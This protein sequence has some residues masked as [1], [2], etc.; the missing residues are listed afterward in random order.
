MPTPDQ[1]KRTQLT[2]FA[3]NAFLSLIM[4][5]ILALPYRARVR[6]MGWVV[7]WVIAPLAGYPKRVIANLDLAWPSLPD[8]EKKRLARAV[9]NNFGRTLIEIYSGAEYK[10]HLAQ[11]PLEGP[12]VDALQ[13]AH[14]AGRPIILVSGH[15]GNHDAIRA[16]V[17]DRFS[18]VG[19]LYRPLGNSYINAHW[20]NAVQGIASPA[21]ARGRRGL[22]EMVKYLRQGN[23]IAL[24]VDQY[25]QEGADLTFFGKQARTTLSAAELA[26][27]YDALFL[28]VFGLRKAD[29]I[30]FHPILQEPIAHS[31]AVQ[32]AQEMNDRLE[33][34]VRQHPEQWFW[35]H[36][37]WKD[38]EAG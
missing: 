33:E 23:I 22:A 29:G 3:Q 15:F 4:R 14:A 16:T 18:P 7:S 37:R 1:S 25:V 12:G 24:L 34:M 10:E 28:P 5:S 21:F 11:T 31:T 35:V 36:R 26:L 27:K 20:E 6:M 13:E 9:P 38:I 19:A 8:A 30:G 2:H 32:M 17:S